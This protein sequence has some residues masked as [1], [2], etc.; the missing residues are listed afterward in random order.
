MHPMNAQ[1]TPKLS[2]HRQDQTRAL[3]HLCPGAPDRLQQLQ[4]SIELENKPTFGFLQH[5]KEPELLC[6]NAQ[7]H[8]HK[9]PE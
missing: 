8:L 4:A 5:K 9:E 1:S 2:Q 6:H 7:V 3:S